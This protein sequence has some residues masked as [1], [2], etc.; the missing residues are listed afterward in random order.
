[1]VVKKGSSGDVWLSCLRKQA[2]LE[3]RRSQKEF[4][5]LRAINPVSR[6][7]NFRNFTQIPSL[8]VNAVDSCEPKWYDRGLKKHRQR[9]APQI[10]KNSYLP[11]RPRDL[12][13]LFR[14]IALL[15]RTFRLSHTCHGALR[16]NFRSFHWETNK[17]SSTMALRSRKRIWLA[18]KESLNR[19]QCFLPS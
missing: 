11:Q 19:R 5:F 16:P 17:M 3:K 14:S 18:R 6:R 10:A 8:H 12:D 1:M 15:D 2:Y 13:A 9:L 7:W 4:F